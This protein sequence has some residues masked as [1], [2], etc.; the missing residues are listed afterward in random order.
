MQ[1]IALGS[2]DGLWHSSST[3][4]ACLAEGMQSCCLLV[5]LS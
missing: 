5:A 1:I 3:G 2:H 4:M